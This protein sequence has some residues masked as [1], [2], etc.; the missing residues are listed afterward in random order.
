MSKSHTKTFVIRSRDVI[1]RLSAY[2]EAQPLKPLLEITVKLHQ[3][4][5]SFVH[6]SLMWLW[7]TFIA[8]EWGWTKNDVHKHFKKEHLVKIYERD[9]EGYAAMLQSIRAVYTSGMKQEAKAMEKEI[10]RMTSTTTATVKQFTEYLNDIEKDMISKGISL[11]HP[12]DYW[13]AMG[14]KPNKQEKNNEHKQN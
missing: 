4:D 1:A 3:K 7:I 5:R 11:P 10:I 13:R 9:E 6:N 14:I 2:L 12:N 8:E